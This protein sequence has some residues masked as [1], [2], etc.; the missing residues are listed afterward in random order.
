LDKYLINEEEAK[1]LDEKSAER[2]I[3]MIVSD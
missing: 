3:T 1:N 2:L